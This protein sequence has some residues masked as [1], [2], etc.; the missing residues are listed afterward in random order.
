[1]LP[2]PTLKLLRPYF[3]HARA[4]LADTELGAWASK[5]RIIHRG[6]DLIPPAVP[7]G[8]HDAV[9]EALLGGKQS[10]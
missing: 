1:M 6:P 10:G 9:Y 4:V 5:V 7:T 2:P 8:V 3:N